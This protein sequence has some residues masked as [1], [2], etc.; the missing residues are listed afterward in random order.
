MSKQ[1]DKMSDYTKTFFRYREDSET[2][3]A[4]PSRVADKLFKLLKRLPVT[5]ERLLGTQRQSPGHKQTV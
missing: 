3:T 1:L 4:R 2:Q 5:S